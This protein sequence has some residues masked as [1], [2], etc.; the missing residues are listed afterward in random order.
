[1]QDNVVIINGVAFL[2]ANGWWT[3]DFDPSVDY[4]QTVEWF[5]QRYGVD[6]SVA[7]T[8][9]NMGINDAAY[10]KNSVQ[11]LQMHQDVKAIVMVSH[12]VP[13]PRLVNHD[14]ELDGHYR[15]NTTG[16]SHLQLCLD[17]DSE[18]K[19]KAWCFGH[20]HRPVD[21]IIDG[22][23][24]VNN[25]RGRGNTPWSQQAYFPKRITVQY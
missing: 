10:L 9:A 15:M 16:N 13:D 18:N 5:A 1:M 4:Q 24:Y 7:A 17:F 11:K 14:L 19:V 20:Y 8:I 23:Q 25:C 3:F 22:I 6:H 21:R 2:A 12:T